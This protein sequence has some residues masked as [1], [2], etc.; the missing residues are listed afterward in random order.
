MAPVYRWPVSADTPA[1]G[2]ERSRAAAAS[3][4]PRSRRA[5][6]ANPIGWSLGRGL[7]R[8]RNGATDRGDVRAL[9]VTDV[10]PSVRSSDETKTSPPGGA[11]LD[12]APEVV[13]YLSNPDTEQVALGPI[14]SQRQVDRVQRIVDESVAQGATVVTGGKADGLY[15]PPTVLRDVT[16]SMPVFTEELFGPIAPVTTFRTDDE[17]VELANAT[18]YGLAAAVQGERAHAD[19][20]ANRLRAGMVHVND[21]PV[22]EEVVAPFGGFGCSG[23]GAHCGGDATLEAFTTWQWVTSR[24]DP[25]PFPF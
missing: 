3:A 8:T 13:A 6:A 20:V 1:A 12:V 18:D 22:N 7:G 24:D 14:I 17:A 19:T 11:L 9:G 10:L 23:N 4:L 5:S 15:Y 25:A 2:I 21:Q 16:P